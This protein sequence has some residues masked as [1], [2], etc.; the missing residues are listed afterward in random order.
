[1]GPVTVNDILGYDCTTMSGEALLLYNIAIQ[2]E[3]HQ[4]IQWT[5]ELISQFMSML[6]GKLDDLEDE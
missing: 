4:T 1:M 3:Q 6:E 2:M 5:N